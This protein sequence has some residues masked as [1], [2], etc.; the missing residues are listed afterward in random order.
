MLKA[1][2]FE[3]E[4]ISTEIWIYSEFQ[5]RSRDLT[6]L[7]RHW[8]ERRKRRRKK[9]TRIDL[10]DENNNNETKQEKFFIGGTKSKLAFK[11]SKFKII[12]N[13]TM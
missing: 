7:M 1:K 11:D 8:N 12:Q 2:K 9:K 13:N 4:N 5:R 3:N 6:M 10:I